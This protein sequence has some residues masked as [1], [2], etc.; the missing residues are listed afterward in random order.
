MREF[1]LTTILRHPNI[2]QSYQAHQDA[3]FYYLSMRAYPGH[4]LLEHLNRHARF[5][6]PRARTV[7]GQIAD[8]V[9]YLHAN[10]VAH[11]DIKPENIVYDVSTTRAVLIDFDQAVFFVRDTPLTDFAG[12]TLYSPPEVLAQRPYDAPASDVWSLG[13]TLYVMTHANHP[14]DHDDNAVLAQRIQSD[15]FPVPSHFSGALTQL[16]T[17]MLTKD[18]AARWTLDDV[19]QS[20]WLAK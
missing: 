19:C 5:S 18:P 10:H 15:N 2:A 9:A 1:A 16:L 20:A 12:T 14:W 6:E 17:G 13:V 11:R 4:D 3:D 8:A 7:F